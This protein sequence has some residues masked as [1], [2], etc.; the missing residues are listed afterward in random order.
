M[1]RLI[2]NLPR[3]IQLARFGKRRERGDVWVNSTPVQMGLLPL[4]AIGSHW[5]PLEAIWRQQKPLE[6]GLEL[7]H[8]V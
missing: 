4:E 2:L 6:W 8:I 5:K 1:G 3:T 7:L